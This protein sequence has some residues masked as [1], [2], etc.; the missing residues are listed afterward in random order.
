M[1]LRSGKP[2][3]VTGGASGIGAAI[4]VRL[5]NEGYSVAIFDLN[6][7]AAQALSDANADAP[8]N[9]K[10]YKVDITDHEGVAAAVAEVETDFGSIY[11]LVNNAGW[12]KAVPFTKTDFDFWQKIVNLNLYGALNVTHAALKSMVKG[13]RGGRVV[14]VGS[15]AGRIGSSGEAVY[16]ACKG[17]QVA[18]MKTLAREHARHGITCNTV[19]P[20]PTMT[21]LTIEVIEQAGEK[22][23]AAMKKG[24]PMGRFAEPEDYP[25]LVAYFVS[26]E[27]G[28]VTGQTISVSGGMSMAG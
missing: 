13:E 2:I 17:G 12:D 5:I 22:Y 16:S 20:G 23:A 4:S 3:I 28:Y 26:D 27:A 7:E 15:D 21:P 19:S 8:G 11:G 25:G 14:T 10:G 9:C 6:L 1:S 24:I 18:L